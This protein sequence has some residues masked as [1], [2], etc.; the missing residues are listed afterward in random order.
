VVVTSELICLWFLRSFLTWASVVSMLFSVNLQR[1][2]YGVVA[3]IWLECGH[4]TAD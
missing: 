2:N 1:S 3:F 4:T